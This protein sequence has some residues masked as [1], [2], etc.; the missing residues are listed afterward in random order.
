MDFAFLSF[1]FQIHDGPIRFG[2]VFSGGTSFL[3][4]VFLSIL[5]VLC[6]GKLSK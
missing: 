5:I 1:P 2:S 4:R 3:F 6:I